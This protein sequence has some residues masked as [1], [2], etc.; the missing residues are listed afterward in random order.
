MGHDSA[1]TWLHLDSS[2]YQI[3]EFHILG[4]AHVAYR[5]TH[6][7]RAHISIQ[8]ERM[9]GD[10]S[11]TLHV[12]F[13]QNIAINVTDPDTPLSLRVYEE[14]Q[15]RLPRKIF[16]RGVSIL[17]SGQVSFFITC[18]NIRVLILRVSAF[19]WSKG[20]QLFINNIHDK[21]THSD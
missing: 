1:K 7:S 10:K 12:G 3:D 8:N 9:F 21:I 6:D 13:H 19:D 4:S 20:V 14:G 11:G 16:L 2:D 15:L 5:N 18:I 17:S